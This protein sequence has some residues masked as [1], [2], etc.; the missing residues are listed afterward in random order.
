MTGGQLVVTCPNCSVTGPVRSLSVI[1]SSVEFVCDHCGARTRIA[2]Y[3]EDD[4]AAQSAINFDS[5]TERGGKPNL[6]P[7]ASPIA[8]DPR[9]TDKLAVVEGVATLPAELAQRYRDVVNGGDD[10]EQHRALVHDASVARQLEHAGVIYRFRLQRL[11][12]DAVARE[13][14]ELVMQLA[15]AELTSDRGAR[16]DADR[17][18]RLGLFAA[19]L[20]AVLALMTSVYIAAKCCLPAPDEFDDQVTT[21]PVGR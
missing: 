20:F 2:S 12:D 7:P 15:M 6:T 17:N 16:P 4:A 1:G 13:M 21:D 19:V 14:R 3:G 8:S 9:R 10:L 18:R 5:D 11:P